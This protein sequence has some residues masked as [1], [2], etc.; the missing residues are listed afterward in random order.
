[1]CVF[2]VLFDDKEFPHVSICSVA[3]SVPF[4]ASMVEMNQH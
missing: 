1:M 4:Q 3:L 2:K